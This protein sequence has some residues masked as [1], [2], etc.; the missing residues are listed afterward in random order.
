MPYAVPNR[1]TDSPAASAVAPDH[2]NDRGLVRVNVR[3]GAPVL[4]ALQPVL[5]GQN[6]WVAGGFAR[7][8]CSPHDA[9]T[10]AGDLDVFFG[11]EASLE[12]VKAKLLKL[13]AFVTREVS[14]FVELDVS[15][16]MS[17]R[18]G[19][20]VEGMSRV[21]S[22]Q[23]IKPF[24]GRSTSEP[25]ERLRVSDVNCDRSWGPTLGHVVRQIDITVCRVGLCDASV[26]WADQ[27]FEK[28]EAERVVRPVCINN[29]ISVMVHAMKYVARGYALRS[30]EIVGLF[31]DWS[32]R[33]EEYRSKRVR[34]SK[35]GL[36]TD[37][38]GEPVEEPV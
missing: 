27:D 34:P 6:G 22:V 9:P 11:D 30:P 33:S 3:R 23:L 32:S 20:S 15:R 12:T 13:G 21:P 25:T 16:V 17:F 1:N 28:D 8:C 2:S 35:T 14:Y 26:G 38:Y 7:W 10:P 5:H 36:G 24:P 37:G 31:E 19:M 29:P 18:D 4:K